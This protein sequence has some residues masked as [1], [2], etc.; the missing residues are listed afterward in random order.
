MYVSRTFFFLYEANK[1]KKYMRGF[2]LL[3]RS[4]EETGYSKTKMRKP[5]IRKQKLG[6]IMFA[7]IYFFL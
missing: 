7:R 3:L 1:N 6:S 2:R 4:Y 5:F